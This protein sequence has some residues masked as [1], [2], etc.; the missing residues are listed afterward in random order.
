MSMAANE[1]VQ[2]NHQRRLSRAVGGDEA[3]WVLSC[4]Y[5]ALEA[6]ETLIEIEGFTD[7]GGGPVESVNIKGLAA[8]TGLKKR[9]VRAALR[10]L[11]AERGSFLR[12]VDLQ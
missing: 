3:L 2:S 5:L 10:A 4:T 7:D 11:V 9:E 8:V 12:R 6:S 1:A